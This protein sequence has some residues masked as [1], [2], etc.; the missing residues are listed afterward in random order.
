[1]LLDVDAVRVSAKVVVRVDDAVAWYYDWNRVDAIGLC[2]GTERLRVA[3][4]QG[5]FLVT[6]CFAIGDGEH[7]SPCCLLKGC[8]Y[9][10]ERQVELAQLSGEISIQLGC[11]M[12]KEWQI[13][14]ADRLKVHLERML[15]KLLACV[16]DC[17]QCNSVN[18]CRNGEDTHR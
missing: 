15:V 8:A 14:G 12:V 9:K 4:A 6:Y 3:G 1:M 18:T 7:C 2:H 16:V 5:L 13:W 11:G 17:E 10:V